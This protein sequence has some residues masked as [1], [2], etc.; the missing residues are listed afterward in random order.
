M[1]IA[2]S[3]YHFH[4]EYLQSLLFFGLAAIGFGID[5][6]YSHGRVSFWIWLVFGLFLAFTIASIILSWKYRNKEQI[7]S[8]KPYDIPVL[9]QDN[10]ISFPE[11]YYFRKSSISQNRFIPLSAINEVHIRT[12]PASFI[13]NNNEVI[14]VRFDQKE[15]LEAYAEKYGIPVSKRVDIWE[16][17]CEPFLDTE[18]DEEYKQR[19]AEQLRE[20]NISDPEA[21]AIRKRIRFVMAANNFAWEWIYLGQFDYLR[22]GGA[23]REKDYWW[24]MEIALRNY[25][26]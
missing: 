12:H 26:L 10:G 20:S 13:I 9:L 14:F 24:S 21:E 1:K 11:G 8:A 5:I 2:S 25:Y 3:K 19:T 7:P 16:N 23:V 15:E 4:K 22:W 18:F 17:I 6:Y